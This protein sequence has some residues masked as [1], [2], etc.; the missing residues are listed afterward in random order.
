MQLA[1]SF[2]EL[3]KAAQHDSRHI[4]AYIGHVD[5]LHLSMNDLNPLH[6]IAS[7]TPHDLA[8]KR[9]TT[10]YIKF[11]YTLCIIHGFLASA[12]E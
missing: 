2:E 5:H 10:Y 6:S 3:K 1:A 9:I 7:N 4:P 11:N 12:K 8:K